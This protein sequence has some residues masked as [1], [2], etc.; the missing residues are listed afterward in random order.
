MLFEHYNRLSHDL[1]PETKR[2]FAYY[3]TMCPNGGTRAIRFLGPDRH[4]TDSGGA[5]HGISPPHPTQEPNFSQRPG[6]TQYADRAYREAC[7][8]MAPARV[9][10]AKQIPMTTRWPKISSVASNA[11]SSI[12]STI[13]PELLIYSVFS[14]RTQNDWGVHSNSNACHSH[15][16]LV[17]E[18]NSFYDSIITMVQVSP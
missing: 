5:G 11:N 14:G 6:R 16:T 10:P 3:G 1:L 17:Q 9:C 15:K 8:P 12:C 4:T 13:L 18:K 2:I 7:R